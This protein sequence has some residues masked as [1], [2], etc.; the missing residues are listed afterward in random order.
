[1]Q[2]V[3]HTDSAESSAADTVA[4]HT[5]PAVPAGGKRAV[6]AGTAVVAAEEHNIRAAVDTQAVAAEDRPVAVVQRTVG[7]K[8]V[9]AAADRRLADRK[10]QQGNQEQVRADIDPGV[11]DSQAQDKAVRVA[12]W[13]ACSAETDQIWPYHPSLENRN[14]SADNQPAESSPRGE[15]IPAY[16]PPTDF[17]SDQWV[18]MPSPASPSGND[19]PAAQSRRKTPRLVYPSPQQAPSKNVPGCAF[20]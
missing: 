8:P 15:F 20:G 19:I 4:D 5:R 12:D 11:A 13:V 2:V 1:M 17:V 3:A 14:R 7:H 16:Q 9:A 18:S 10:G 6:V